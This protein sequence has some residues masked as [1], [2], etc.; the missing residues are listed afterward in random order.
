VSQAA[1]CAHAVNQTVDQTSTQASAC[2]RGRPTVDCF[3]R[4][5]IYLWLVDRAQ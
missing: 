1:A 4:G 2:A 5:Q 3:D